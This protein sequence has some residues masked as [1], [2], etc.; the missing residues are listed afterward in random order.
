MVHEPK[1]FK[2]SEEVLAEQVPEVLEERRRLGLEGLV[3]ALSAVIINVE[4]YNQRAAA[5]EM[6]RRTGMRLVGVYSGPHYVTCH[7]HTGHS[8]DILLRSRRDDHHPFRPFNDHPK[9]RVLPNTRVE[10]MVF[11]A[12]NIDRYVEIQHERG[13][14]FLTREPVVTDK[15]SFI[16]THPSP[17]TGTSVGLIQWHGHRHDYAASAVRLLNWDLEKPELPHLKNIHGIDHVALR[18]EA[19]HRDRAILEFMGLT[20][21]TFESAIY[22]ESLN[23]ITNVTRRA[24]G[25]AAAVF[26]SGIS[27]YVDDETS[28]PTEKYVHNY[29]AR[30]HHIAFHTEHIDE[31]FAAL[32]ADGQPFLIELVGSSEEGLKQTFTEPSPETLVVHEYIHRFGHFTGFFTKSNVTALTRATGKQ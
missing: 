22:V 6:L 5:A 17:F 7:L 20:N 8:T 9:S 3:G 23:S 30:A 1:E 28:G 18:V 2:N 14:K 15:Y 24:H 19:A 29:G 10:T 21:Y 31:T 32:K 11:Q 16:Q 25:D 26:T 4:H 27:P 12:R 13:V